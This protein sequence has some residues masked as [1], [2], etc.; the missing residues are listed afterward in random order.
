[1]GASTNSLNNNN[2]DNISRSDEA[3]NINNDNING[4]DNKLL[5][6]EIQVI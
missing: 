6:R 4:S 5:F 2:N 1:M 3:N